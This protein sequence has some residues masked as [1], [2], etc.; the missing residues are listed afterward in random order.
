VVSLPRPGVSLPEDL[1]GEALVARLLAEYRDWSPADLCALQQVGRV[2]DRLRAL[3]GEIA[4]A[5][6]ATGT[7]RGRRLNLP[8]LR[9]ERQ[10]VGLFMALLRQLNLRVE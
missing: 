4:E 9:A 6:L 8:L 2:F 1:N 5:G 7:G 3:Q 10:T